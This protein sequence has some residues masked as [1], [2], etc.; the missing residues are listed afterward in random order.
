[1]LR[2]DIWLNTKLVQ[3][4]SADRPDGSNHNCLERAAKIFFRAVLDRHLK[5]MIDLCAVREQRHIGFAV[6][7]FFYRRA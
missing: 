2:L 3:H 7:Y 5:E 4:F 1:M 6:R